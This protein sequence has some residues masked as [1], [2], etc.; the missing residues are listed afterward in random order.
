MGAPQ[1]SYLLKHCCGSK[2]A[3]R[4]QVITNS[5]YCMLQVLDLGQVVAG[6]FCGA[7]DCCAV[8]DCK[9]KYLT[10][11]SLQACCMLQTEWLLHAIA[12]SCGTVCDSSRLLQCWGTLEPM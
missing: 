8:P 6:N 7:G 10:T 11:S 1:Q 3:A 12:P 4:L 5:L 2:A 9:S